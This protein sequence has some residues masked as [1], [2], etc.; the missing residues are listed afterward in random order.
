MFEFEPRIEVMQDIA[1]RAHPGTLCGADVHPAD[2]AA[3]VLVWERLNH[4][5]RAR[6]ETLALD[7]AF[8]I[9]WR[10]IERVQGGPA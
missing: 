6:M 1:R 4:T 8:E 10:I 9:A 7:D 2:A 5:N 3:Y